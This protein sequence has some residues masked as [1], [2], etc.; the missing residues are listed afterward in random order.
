MSSRFSVLALRFRCVVLICFGI[1]F[2]LP[3]FLS[4]HA[5]EP[6]ATPP[7][8]A[9]MYR[10][11]EQWKKEGLLPN[12]MSV[13][14]VLYPPDLMR[15]LLI[16]PDGATIEFDNT[17]RVFNAQFAIDTMTSYL[18]DGRVIAH[19]LGVPF[20]HEVYIQPL[21]SDQSSFVPIEPRMITDPVTG[22]T[23]PVPV[24]RISS[25]D[26]AARQGR[27]VVIHEFTHT[28]AECGTNG[29]VCELLSHLME[30]RMGIRPVFH[31]SFPGLVMDFAPNGILASGPFNAELRSILGG[32]RV[33]AHEHAFGVLLGNAL[34][35]RSGVPRLDQIGEIFDR[36]KAARQS[37]DPDAV[38]KALGFKGGASELLRAVQ[39]AF[40][41]QLA[42]AN[43]A[44]I[45]PLFDSAMQA[46]V[47]YRAAHP[48]APVAPS[49]LSPLPVGGVLDANPGA[50]L[51]PLRFLPPPSPF[52]TP[53]PYV[54]P[55]VSSPLAPLS[56]TPPASDGPVTALPPVL[57]PPP[58]PRPAPTR[59][60]RPALPR[61]RPPRLPFV[62]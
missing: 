2:S 61:P 38:A 3:I 6:V 4:A 47:A 28:I 39:K 36:L 7:Y 57:T 45:R 51:D 9:A 32:A 50:F 54:D 8:V 26:L 37:S 49:P 25:A 42:Q 23:R 44:N 10:V 35:S 17:H 41:D 52:I 12:N 59:P 13:Q 22:L 55:S 18:R 34:I 33:P 24:I 29:Q 21:I 46:E 56:P 53:L 30:Q 20:P 62:P 58:A 48:P 19:T 60:A 11:F 15:G 27:R 43:S 5:A 1:S 40:Y 16:V 31:E 14:V